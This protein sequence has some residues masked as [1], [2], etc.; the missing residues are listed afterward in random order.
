[1]DSVIP[2]AF[3]YYVVQASSDIQFA[4]PFIE[5]GTSMHHFKLMT[6]K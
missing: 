2:M 3:V 4:D 6:D 1:M 5:F